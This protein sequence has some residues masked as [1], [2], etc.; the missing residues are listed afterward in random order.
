L[1][2]AAQVNCRLII[3]EN[4][5][6][7]NNII[8]TDKLWPHSYVNGFYQ[9]EFEKIREQPISL[10]EIGFRHGASLYLW[11]RFFS[12]VQIL[13]LDNGS[14]VSVTNESPVNNVW[15]DQENIKTRVGDA[16]DEKFSKVILEKFDVIIDDRPHSLESQIKFLNLYLDKLKPGGVAIIEDLQRY[17]GI[18][19]W[20]LL[21]NTPLS[22][23]VEFYDFR[24]K[25]GLKDDMLYVVRNTGGKVI[26]SRMKLIL[27]AIGYT[28]YDP[29]RIIFMKFTN[30]GR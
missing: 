29:I 27:R 9:Q 14:D 30:K 28:L 15:L 2:L 1:P 10:L 3:E 21:L 26:L 5:C 24:K 16:Y 17:G 18:L 11:S 23:E 22:Y 19:L 8:G 25:N 13:G 12:N 4:L 20:P 7:S 6:I